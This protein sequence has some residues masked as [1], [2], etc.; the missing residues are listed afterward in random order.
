MRRGTTDADIFA[1][2]EDQ[3][4]GEEQLTAQPSAASLVIPVQ[5]TARAKS[6][7]EAADQSG[8]VA[9]RQRV[10][11][12]RSQTYQ[13]FRQICD[14]LRRELQRAKDFLVD[15]KVIEAGLEVI[16]EVEHLW[17]RLYEC[18]W[19]EG[20]CLK[21]VVVAVQAQL[22]NSCWTQ[23]H[24]QFLDDIVG[25]LRVRYL[26]NEAVVRECH[27]LIELHGLDPFRGGVSEPEVR[28]RFRI[29][30]VVET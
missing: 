18:P 13:V 8:R 7:Q 16:V 22:N 25:R 9:G 24:V 21:R 26:I 23:A 15:G 27:E 2:V 10:A 17:E 4:N 3:L 11:A 20:E 29:Q 5:T 14:D 6:A 28:K 30:E 1:P 12:E 19:G